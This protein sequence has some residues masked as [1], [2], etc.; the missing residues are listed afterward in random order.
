[1]M[2]I[3]ENQLGNIILWMEKKLEKSVSRI[4]ITLRKWMNGF[5][6]MEILRRN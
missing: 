2:Q 4:D 5:R 1:M 3:V 6:I